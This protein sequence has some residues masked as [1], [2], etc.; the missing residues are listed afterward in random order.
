MSAMRRPFRDEQQAPP[1]QP[2]TL[3]QDDDLALNS[4]T[5]ATGAPYD[6]RELLRVLQLLAEDA[7][8]TPEQQQRNLEAL[9]AAMD[10]GRSDDMKL[11][12]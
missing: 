7:T 8:E 6:P 2:V 11:F 1:L 12:P 3:P 5:T 10:E 9:M 4:L